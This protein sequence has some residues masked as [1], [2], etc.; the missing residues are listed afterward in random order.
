V[1]TLSVILVFCSGAIMALASYW[2]ADA[3]SKTKWIT[4]LE[5]QLESQKKEMREWQNKALVRSGGGS[6][7][8]KATPAT[9]KTQE[10][11]P[12]VVTRQQLEHRESDAVATPVTIHAH[13]V[14]YPRV[15]KTLEQV[16]EIIEAHK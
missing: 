16:A 1:E 10:I 3:R 11:T 2:Y 4:Q 8:A 14:S 12:R 6:L 13:D 5:S 9:P 15:N 7:D